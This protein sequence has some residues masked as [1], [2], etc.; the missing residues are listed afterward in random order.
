MTSI[1][2]DLLLKG[3]R[4][5]LM[6]LGKDVVST[7]TAPGTLPRNAL[8]LKCNNECYI[9]EEIC[10]FPIVLNALSKIHIEVL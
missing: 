9:K 7:G 4:R 5:G 6:M 10:S 3:C 1:L 2:S 8:Y